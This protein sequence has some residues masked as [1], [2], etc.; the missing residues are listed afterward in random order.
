MI[1]YCELKCPNGDYLRLDTA[2][3]ELIGDWLK[4]VFHEFRINPGGA[5]IPVQFTL[6]IR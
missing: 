4:A 3:S 2:D 6:T 1:L 5:R